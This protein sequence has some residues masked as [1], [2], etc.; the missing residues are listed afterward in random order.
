MNARTAA[1][2]AA[3][4][5][6][7]FLGGAP[8]WYK[9]GLLIALL[10]NVPLYAFAGPTVAAWAITAEF[11]ATLAL[12]LHA[13][14]L[15]PGGL[16]ALEGVL[17]GLAQPA[18][19]YQEVEHGL[20][21]LLLLVFMVAAIA[22]ME[23]LLVYVFS[24][25]LTAV[26]SPTA[27]ALGMCL[28]GAVLSAF[29]D[30]LTVIAVVMT[31]ALGFYRVY[32]ATAAGLAHAGDEQLG[33]ESLLEPGRLVELARLRAALRGL[34][35]HAAVGTALGGVCTLVGEPQNLL[36]GHAVG[37]NFIGFARAMAPVSLPVLFAGLLT[38]VL[39]E[40]FGLFGF[41]T[42]IPAAARAALL[43]FERDA[44]A[45]RTPRDRWRLLARAAA[46][47]L[48]VVALA[49]HWA[50]VGLIGLAIVVLLTALLGVVEE[51]R[52][53]DAM[54][55]A[56]PFTALLVV[57]FAVVAVIRGQQLFAPVIH[58]V[59]AQQGAAQA[60]WMY[61]A[62][63]LLSAVSDNVFV[64]TIYMGELQHAFAA[65]QLAP[66][67]FAHL[68]VAVNAGTNIPS[69]AT[70]NGQAALLFLLT[71]ALAPLLRLSYGRMCWMALPYLVVTSAVGW[72]AVVYLVR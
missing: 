13:H 29:L 12:A 72:V 56:L 42:P 5:A 7:S 20:P 10:F 53:A 62:N 4:A 17:L 64:A 60:G 63:G 25:L 48:L 44:A 68:A 50:E 15:A 16:L 9:A 49:F 35:M 27:M 37:W 34:L 36:I 58:A 11:I 70:P 31:V 71:S 39:V 45:R 8:R 40:R 19:L 43:Q 3:A 66:A 26:H 21:I 47:V 54:K 6:A 46:A 28:A 1:G 38:C 24:R 30:A 57:F 33:R 52:L 67:Q 61:L 32:F 2:L 23:E 14:P 69:I 41:G 59:L 18:A 65:G 55:T 51:H 22:F